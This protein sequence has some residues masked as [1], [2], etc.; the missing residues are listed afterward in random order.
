LLR[1][2]T[3]ADRFAQTC[4]LTATA[5]SLSR[6]AI[7][8]ANPDLSPEEVDLKFV[9]LHYGRRLANAVRSYLESRL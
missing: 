7:A 2:A 3:V 1:S 6:R 9:E 4:S 5:I 8:R